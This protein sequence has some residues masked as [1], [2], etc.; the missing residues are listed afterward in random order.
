MKKISFIVRN[1]PEFLKNKI[2]LSEELYGMK[3]DN[4][5]FKA[6]KKA[7]ENL[8]HTFSTYDLLSPK[9][10]DVIICLD[11][12][13]TFKEIGVFNKPSYLI[14]SEPAVYT[15][16][17]WDI[18]NHNY[19]KKV[20]T[21]DKTLIT[22]DKYVHY[23]FA[24][25]FE[26]YKK[27]DTVTEVIFSKRKL[28]SIIAGAMQV[29][30]PHETSKSLLH[31]RFKITDW[32]G[33][34]YPRDLDI[35]GRSLLDNKFEHFKG[36]RYLKKFKLNFLVKQIANFKSKYIKKSFKG[37]IPALQK[38]EIQNNYNFNICFE[39]SKTNSYM[40][41]KIFDCFVSKTV[42]IYFGAPN[43]EE[44]IPASTFINFADFKTYNQ[45]Y[46]FI[47]AMNFNEYEKYIKSTEEFLNSDK[48]DIFKTSTF[49]KTI[50]NNL[51]FE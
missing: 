12:V 36:A 2:F 7:F 37:F 1:D 33:K 51:S 5:P 42:P 9:D 15:P 6:L 3:S 10:A 50:V 21:Y 49:V 22:S 16:K 34:N 46:S 23:N 39:N 44:L 45:L 32:F 35:F 29:S 14:I 28:C 31:E 27:F 11:E 20:F 43:I 17:N 47:K 4:F 19:F 13:N 8:G 24:I 26:N 18:D 25:D 40:T 41:E 48:I 30:P 38:L